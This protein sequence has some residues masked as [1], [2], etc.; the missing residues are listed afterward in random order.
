MIYYQD[1]LVGLSYIGNYQINVSII[2]RIE[3]AKEYTKTPG[4][5]YISEGP[6]SG[7]DFRN[8][9]LCPRIREAIE[10][11]EKLIIVLDGTH[12]YGTSFLEEAFGG[13][14]REDHIPYE[15]IVAIIEIISD[16]EEYLVDDIMQYLND[17]ADASN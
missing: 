5:R 8:I 14:I 12:G 10:N 11:N 9:I 13:L 17:A 2:M 6:F 15:K 3:I 4:P 7:E 1:P 16:E